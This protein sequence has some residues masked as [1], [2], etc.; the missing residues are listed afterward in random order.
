MFRVITNKRIDLTDHEWILFQN[1]CESYKSYGGESLF[2]DLFETDKNGIIQFLKPPSKK[3]TSLEIFLFLV[4]IFNHQHIR[5]MENEASS[6]FK[7]LKEK[8]AENNALFLELKNKI[9]A[10]DSTK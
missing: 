5:A 4:S 8:Q 9:A 1:I 2:E 6:L 7:E 3:Q 10:L